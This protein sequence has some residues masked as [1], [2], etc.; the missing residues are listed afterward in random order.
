MALFK[1]QN[2]IC[3]S[4]WEVIEIIILLHFSKIKNPK[5]G[6]YH[7]NYYRGLSGIGIFLSY[8]VFLIGN[9][10]KNTINVGKRFHKP[11]LFRL[12][13]S[14]TADNIRK[15]LAYFWYSDV[16]R[17]CKKE[18]SCM[19]WVKNEGSLANSIWKKNEV[20]H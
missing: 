8:K 4:I 19:K 14:I 10:C 12:S 6:C 11:K 3:N 16:F 1:K 13:L 7:Y 5:N 9:R 18:T 2:S 17:G 20:I 15:P